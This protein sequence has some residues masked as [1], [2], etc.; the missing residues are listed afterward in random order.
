MVEIIRV[1]PVSATLGRQ[2]QHPHMLL[3]QFSGNGVV[4]IGEGPR[5]RFDVLMPV[6]G[7]GLVLR[8]EGADPYELRVDFMD[9]ARE[10][11]EQAVMRMTNDPD[12]RDRVAMERYRNDLRN[13]DDEDLARHVRESS[14][15]IEEEQSWLEAVQAAQRLRAKAGAA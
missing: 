11:A 4:A 13:L 3:T 1:G 6:A 12:A 2:S 8:F 5:H 14:R 10:L 9:C 7:F 15:I